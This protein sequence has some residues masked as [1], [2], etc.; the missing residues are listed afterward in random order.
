MC[1][2]KKHWCDSL[3][4][5]KYLK[6]LLG[7]YPGQRIGLIWDKAP[8]HNSKFVQD[9][10]ADYDNRISIFTLPGGMTSV[11][12]VGDICLNH[13]IKVGMRQ[14]YAGWRR[15]QIEAQAGA[16][17]IR[18]RFDRDAFLRGLEGVIAGF[19]HNEHTARTIENTFMSCG[20]NIWA[21]EETRAVFHAH[22]AKL[23]ENGLYRALLLAQEAE[24]L[25]F[26][27]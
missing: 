6:H 1:F 3:V 9:F 26:E 12:Q 25:T 13:P 16:G 24:D 17:H 2:Q 19:N 23:S 11:M 22:L 15:Q 5:V 18:L 27:S 4:I 14:W 10:L 20:Q 21:A 7:A 8:A